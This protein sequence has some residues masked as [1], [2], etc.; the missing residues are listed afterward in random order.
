MYTVLSSCNCTGT[1]KTSLHHRPNRQK[2][3][4]IVIRSNRILLDFEHF[5]TIFKK[6]NALKYK[7]KCREKNVVKMYFSYYFFLFYYPM[8]IFYIETDRINTPP[9]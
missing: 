1:R 6:I 9:V 2:R 4:K 3:V 7:Y 5:P 8:M